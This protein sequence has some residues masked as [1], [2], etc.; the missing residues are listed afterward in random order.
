MDFATP[1]A[2]NTCQ[3]NCLVCICDDNH[4]LIEFPL[5]LVEGC[6]RFAGEG[7]AYDDTP[8]IKKHFIER[9]EGLTCFEHHVIGNVDEV[10]DGANSSE[11]KASTARRS[12]RRKSAAAGVTLTDVSPAITP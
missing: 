5:F 4:I 1:T 3:S 8:L 7:L 11:L 2:H 9:M 12:M 6:H 10:I